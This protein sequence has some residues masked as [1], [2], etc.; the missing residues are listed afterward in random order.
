MRKNITETPKKNRPI[1]GPLTGS[2]TV[3]IDLWDRSSRYCILNQEGEVVTA[4]AVA[5]TKKDLSRVFGALRHSR[6]LA[7]E[8][9]TRSPWVA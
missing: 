3:G 7:L 1:R 6:R 5:T 8:V 2:L 9:G 4:G